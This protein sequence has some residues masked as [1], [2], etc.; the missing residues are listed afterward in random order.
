MN[1]QTLAEGIGNYR[2]GDDPITISSKV[3][4][5]E[6]LWRISMLCFWG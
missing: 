3:I 1:R 6:D 5:R 2:M 4:I